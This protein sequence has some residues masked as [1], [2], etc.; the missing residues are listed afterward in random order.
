MNNKNRIERFDI[1]RKIVANMTSESWETI[2]HVCFTYEPEV[3]GM[4][5]VLK[6]INQNLEKEEKISVNTA[7]LKIIV[8]GLKA[9]PN[10]NGHLH[11][12][13]KYLRG[14]IETMEHIDISMPVLFQSGKMMTVNLH[15]MEHR[16][17]GQIRDYIADIRRR[18]ANTD[19]KEAMYEVSKYD[20]IQGLKKGK[21]KQAVHRLIGLKVGKHKVKTM[22]SRERKQYHRI[23]ESD[24]LTR[25]DLK[26]GTITVSNIG[27]IYKGWRGACTLLEIIPPQLAAIGVGAVQSR[28]I[29]EG[30][31][32]VRVGKVL[33]FT[34]AFDHRAL[35]GHLWK[36]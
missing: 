26:Q 15:H 6:E 13:R 24:R 2:P 23:S 14:E 22:N 4:L 8:E 11:F 21:I 33:P 7:V 20:T 36:N 31:G 25:H 5:E 18:V 1:A 10:M 35:D 12:N 29:A 19:M 16:S 30:D 9:C 34:I 32:S 17:M 27:S 28:P 3:T